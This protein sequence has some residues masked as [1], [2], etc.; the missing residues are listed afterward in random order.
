MN[1]WILVFVIALSSLAAAQ[2]QPK[3]HWAAWE[4]F[5]GTWVGSGSGQPGQGAGEFSLKPELQGAVLVRHNYAEYPASKDK[6]A[7]RHDDLMVIYA[8]GESTRA[9]YWDNERHVIHYLA[10]VSAEKLVFVSD[11]AQ[12]GPRYR[13]TYVKT[14]ADTLRLTFEIAPPNDRGAFK[15]YITAEAKRKS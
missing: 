11:A 5:L 3:N 14:G 13:L 1:R 12:P 10:E 7:Y 6:P 9:D 8:E 4:P 2:T 15:T